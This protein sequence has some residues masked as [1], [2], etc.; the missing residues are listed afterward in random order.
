MNLDVL[1]VD[2]FASRKASDAAPLPELYF[3]HVAST[4]SV[5]WSGSWKNLRSLCG[6]FATI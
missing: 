1:E 2:F 4:I 5:R 3:L 6:Y